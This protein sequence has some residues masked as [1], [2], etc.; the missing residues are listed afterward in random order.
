MFDSEQDCNERIKEVV[1]DIKIFSR[2]LADFEQKQQ[3][4]F[5]SELEYI[6]N[7]KKP[8]QFDN[9]KS[10]RIQT[11]ASAFQDAIQAIGGRVEITNMAP[12]SML[13]DVVSEDGLMADEPDAW[14]SAAAPVVAT[15]KKAK[16]SEAAAQK[17]NGKPNTFAI[18]ANMVKFSQANKAINKFWQINGP[19]IVEEIRNREKIE[20]GMNMQ[21]NPNQNQNS[22]PKK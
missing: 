18:Q 8:A 14:P 19:K 3:K 22:S 15:K 13:A 7:Q 12:P 16:N 1:Q 21:A 2:D 20:E 5:Q 9:E 4:E 6:F 11:V 10:K 17:S